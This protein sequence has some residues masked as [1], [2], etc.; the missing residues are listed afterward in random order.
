MSDLYKNESSIPASFNPL[1]INADHNVDT[2][3]VVQELL[4]NDS[5]NKLGI[6]KVE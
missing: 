2:A 5:Y 4:E 6:V 1:V 3:K